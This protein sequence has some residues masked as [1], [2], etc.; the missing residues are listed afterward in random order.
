MSFLFLSISKV[1]AER[2]DVYVL[3]PAAWLRTLKARIR[4]IKSRDPSKQIEIDREN[5]AV[6]LE[7]ITKSGSPYRGMGVSASHVQRYKEK[8]VKISRALGTTQRA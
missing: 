5:V 7:Q 6:F 1:S 3:S 8:W 4:D 2:P